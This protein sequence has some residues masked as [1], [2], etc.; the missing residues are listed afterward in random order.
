MKNLLSSLSGERVG[1]SR[2]A[3][4]PGRPGHRLRYTRFVYGCA[5]R[6]TFAL[7]TPDRAQGFHSP[8]PLSN[9]FSRSCAVLNEW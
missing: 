4:E 7:G 5:N 9:R 1:R 8:Y 6:A 2:S 3:A